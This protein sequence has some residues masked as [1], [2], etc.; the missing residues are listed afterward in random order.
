MN[1]VLHKHYREDPNFRRLMLEIF[2]ER[3]PTI[4]SWRPQE[5]QDAN[6]A[7]MEEVKYASAMQQGFDLLYSILLGT[8]HNG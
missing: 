7:L 8:H 2:E 1:S 5:T 4:P 3:R 6:A